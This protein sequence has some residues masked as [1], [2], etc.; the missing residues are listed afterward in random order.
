[1]S[2]V[3]LRRIVLA[4]QEVRNVARCYSDHRPGGVLDVGLDR[5][6]CR[7]S[8]LARRAGGS[9]ALDHRLGGPIVLIPAYGVP[10]AFLIHSYS[11]IGLLRRTSQQPR[12]AESLH[13]GMDAARA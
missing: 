1:M 11:L 9:I 12:R 8:R 5:L 2:L 4:P 10:R 3:P 6:L 13:Y 7:Y